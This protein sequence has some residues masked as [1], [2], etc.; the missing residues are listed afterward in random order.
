MHSSLSRYCVSSIQLPVFILT[1]SAHICIS[2]RQKILYFYQFH[3][4]WYRPHCTL[5][6]E[7]PSTSCFVSIVQNRNNFEDCISNLVAIDEVNIN[8]SL[9]KSIEWY[10]ISYSSILSYSY[11]LLTTNVVHNLELRAFQ[12]LIQHL[13][14]GLRIC[15]PSLASSISLGSNKFQST[16]GSLGS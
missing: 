13:W 7:I 1:N 5:D 10:L 15:T 14:T 3:A 9:N 12:E 6:F 8:G 11:I 2:G 16:L 4:A